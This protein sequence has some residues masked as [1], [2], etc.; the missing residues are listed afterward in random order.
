MRSI[1]CL[2]S[3]L[4]NSRIRRIRRSGILAALLVFGGAP[5]QAALNV[6][7]SR[8]VLQV[9]PRQ[10]RTGY[11]FL[12]NRGDTPL[13][14]R[15]EPEDW[16][17]GI[18]GGRGLVPWLSVTPAQLSLRPGRR[19]KVTYV[20]RVPQHASGEL[21]AQIF[22]TTTETSEAVSLR[23]RLGTMLY[24]GVKGT[25]HIAGEITQVEVRY[26]ASTP[27]VATPDRLDVAFG[28]HNQ[29]N[30]HLI[31]EG[32]V[33]VRDVARQPVATIALPAGWGLLPH[34]QEIYHALQHG[35]HLKPGVYTMEI[36]VICGKDLGHPTAL[37]KMLDVII[38]EQGLVRQPD[39]ASTHP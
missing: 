15:V 38:D 13:Q 33:V 10:T 21:R 34:E 37:T 26:I 14:V 29:G 11:F 32:Q 18:T 8:V 1:D 7:P 22:F 12:E 3:G 30:V 28:I 2:L 5:L 19:G 31:P 36:D 6:S 9:K 4:S 25:E 24:V 16:A 20:I 27:G 17:G 35:V 39:P 23:S